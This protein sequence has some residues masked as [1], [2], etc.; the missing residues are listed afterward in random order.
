MRKNKTIKN[1]QIGEVVTSLS[2]QVRIVTA[3]LPYHLY[4][5]LVQCQK[6]GI[7]EN[8]APDD[9]TPLCTREVVL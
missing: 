4:G 3:L 9:L 6:D 7:I 2:G 8:F 5:G 1:F